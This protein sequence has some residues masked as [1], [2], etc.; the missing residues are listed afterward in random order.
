MMIIILGVALV[1]VALACMQQAISI[2]KDKDGIFPA[3]VT[4]F[5]RFILSVCRYF[6]RRN[7]IRSN[8]R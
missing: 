7:S 4:S 2:S 1:I 6:Y 5:F 8:D 3:I